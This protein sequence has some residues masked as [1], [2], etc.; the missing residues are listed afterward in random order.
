M[1]NNKSEVMNFS[2]KSLRSKTENILLIICIE[3]IKCGEY[4]AI[5]NEATV[6][7]IAIPKWS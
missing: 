1:I 7:T 6:K 5:R 4:A 3:S 2:M